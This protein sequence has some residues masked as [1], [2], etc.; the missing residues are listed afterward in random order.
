MAAFDIVLWDDAVI[1]NSLLI[2]KIYRH[3]FLQKGISHV[4]F[5]PEDVPDRGCPP[6][7][8]AGSSQSPVRF[9]SLPDIVISS[10]V[11]IL[12]VD[13]FHHLRLLRVNDKVPVFILVIP[14]EP[15]CA[16]LDL[17]LLKTV[18]KPYPHVLGKALAL[19][20]RKGSHDCKKHLP[21]RIQGI[22]V[23]LLEENRDIQVFQLPDVFE[24]VKRI[25]GKS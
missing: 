25:P 23:F 24:A 18:L 5:I 22:D 17:P 20:L 1:Y 4:L 13:P 10:P 8:F 15:V 7:R 19:L 2:Q 6:Y 21:L 12:P 9:K 3:C 14:E 16:Y 11:Q